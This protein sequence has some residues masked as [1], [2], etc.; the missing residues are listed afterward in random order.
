MPKI[1]QD[2]DLRASYIKLRTNFN[3]LLAYYN[4][5]Y[6]YDISYDITH[7]Q[8]MY[9]V[10]KDLASFFDEGQGRNVELVQAH[11]NEFSRRFFKLQRKG[12]K[13]PNRNFDTFIEETFEYLNQ[14]PEIDKIAMQ[15]IYF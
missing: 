11:P 4:I 1:R 3:R 5:K 7:A 10:K 15:R 8:C 9:K 13:D 12:E 2:D 6:G 14:H